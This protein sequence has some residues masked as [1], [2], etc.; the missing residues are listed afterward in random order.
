LDKIGIGYAAAKEINPQIIYVSVTG[1]GQ[2]GPYAHLAGHDLNY[3]L[4]QA[5]WA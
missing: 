5:Y 1:Y 4:I 3:W 2:T